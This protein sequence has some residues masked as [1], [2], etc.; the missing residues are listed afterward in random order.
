MAFVFNCIWFFLFGWWQAIVYLLL[1]L[2][3][4]ITII[5]IPIAKSLFEFAKLCALPFDKEIITET[6]LKGSNNVS[7]IRKIGG[8]IAN[9]MWFPIGI[10]CALEY[11]IAALVCFIT[12]IGIPAGIVYCKATKFIIFPIGAKVVS[13]KHAYASAVANELERRGL[14]SVNTQS[15]QK[16]TQNERP[17][18]FNYISPEVCVYALTLVIMLFVGFLV[19]F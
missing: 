7:I 10:V 14:Y 2:I 9:M 18:I 11:L 17:E 8:I 5:G 1:S 15:S 12:V 19:Y 16:I 6:E 13:K 4:A 3:F